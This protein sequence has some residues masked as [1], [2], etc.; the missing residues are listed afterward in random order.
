MPRVFLMMSYTLMRKKIR[1]IVLGL[2]GFIMSNAQANNLN[3]HTYDFPS[4]LSLVQAPVVYASF[5]NSWFNFEYDGTVLHRFGST[6]FNV[7][8]EKPESHTQLN[9][10]SLIYASPVNEKLHIA[11]GAM[12]VRELSDA[13]QFSNKSTYR[14]NYTEATYKT[15]DITAAM[16]YSVNEQL[17]LGGGIDIVRTAIT[18][19]VSAPTEI[20]LSPQFDAL[21]NNKASSW[22]LGWHAGASIN[23]PRQYARL[24]MSYRSKVHINTRG[25]SILELPNNLGFRVNN[26]FQ[27]P[28]TL[29]DTL[30]VKWSQLLNE[31]W[32]WSLGYHRTFWSV[33]SVLD[34]K[35][36]AGA[37]SQTTPLSFLWRDTSGYTLVLIRKLEPK[38]TVAPSLSYFQS[39]EPNASG[40]FIGSID[41]FYQWSKT[42]KLH[43][44]Y[45]H[46]LPYRYT[47]VPVTSVSQL[48]GSIRRWEN[49]VGMSVSLNL[50]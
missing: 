22:G 2:V 5:A 18:F 48:Q 4:E 19:N 1:S 36:I 29:P 21:S 8:G 44:F 17:S 16:A 6:F 27:I 14:Y 35:N 20:S 7:I 50:H 34:F 31:N 43:V 26:D 45:D 25:R 42:I 33:I 47:P 38:W 24:S 41:I 40:Y 9:F 15:L 37:A 46:S 23:F 30:R 32:A 49:T 10:P 11:L 28:I 39:Q 12:G 3:L 13:V